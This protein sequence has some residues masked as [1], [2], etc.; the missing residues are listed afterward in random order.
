MSQDLELEFFDHDV[1]DNVTKLLIKHPRTRDDDMLLVATYYY[2]YYPNLVK[3]SALDFLKKFSESKLVSS[4]LI[5]RTRR[6]LQEHN[7]H[8]RGTKWKERHQ[9][10]AEVKSD[11]KKVNH[12]RNS[13]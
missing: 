8:L 6:K 13:I 10:Q 5:T 3:G 2:I 4:D 11:L 7:V 12:F 1:T 9:K